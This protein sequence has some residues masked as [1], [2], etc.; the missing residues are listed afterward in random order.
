MAQSLQRRVHGCAA[1][2]GRRSPGKPLVA[3][4]RFVVAHRRT[5]EVQRGEIRGQDQRL[6]EL[7]RFISALEVAPVGG[8][9][10]QL[11]RAAKA[12]CGP[13]RLT[14]QH[15]RAGGLARA[16]VPAHRSQRICCGGGR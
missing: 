7:S 8:G 13:D 2:R 15:F 14:Q 1:N 11:P 4:V 6:P 16:A 9:D 10:H 5:A 12:E 3:I